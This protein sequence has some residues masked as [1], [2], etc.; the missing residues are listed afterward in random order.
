MDHESDSQSEKTEIVGYDKST[1][2]YALR[3]VREISYVDASE[4]FER[5]R[6]QREVIYVDGSIP[7]MT[8]SYGEDDE[9]F[10]YEGS[11]Q[12]DS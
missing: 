5:L 8:L 3:T 2:R 6:N 12:D 9:I 4:I 10:F 11:G 7:K 1:G